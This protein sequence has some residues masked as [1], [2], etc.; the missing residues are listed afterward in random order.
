M[1]APRYC[2]FY[3]SKLRIAIPQK[4]YGSRVHFTIP[5]YINFMLAILTRF[6]AKGCV[7]KFS[8]RLG[9]YNPA[10]SH[11]LLAL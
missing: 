1:M 4:T 11:I 6:V 3:R 5:N 9:A 10:D 8:I 7:S 2:L